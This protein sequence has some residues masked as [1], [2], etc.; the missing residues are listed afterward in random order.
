M[1]AAAASDSMS[2]SLTRLLKKVRRVCILRKRYPT[3][4]LL[5]IHGVPIRID[6]SPI[7]P[8]DRV[9]VEI[10]PVLLQIVREC[11]GHQLDEVPAPLA[12]PPPPLHRVTDE[13]VEEE[14]GVLCC[15]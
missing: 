12:R 14:D 2:K 10:F 15:N 6:V 13:V 1:V 11:L 9:L 8:G 7:L 4:S 3:Y 5:F